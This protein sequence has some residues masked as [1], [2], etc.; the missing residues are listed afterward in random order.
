MEI[1]VQNGN[2]AI[3]RYLSLSLSLSLSHRGVRGHAGFW[4]SS[5]FVVARGA[6]GSIAKHQTRPTENPPFIHSLKQTWKLEGGGPTRILAPLQA[7]YTRFPV[8]FRGGITQEHPPETVNIRPSSLN[9]H[10]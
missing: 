9:P 7:A 2:G 10:P 4:V 1:G 5:S 3:Y 6:L 8:L